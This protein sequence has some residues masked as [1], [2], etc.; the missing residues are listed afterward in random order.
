MLVKENIRQQQSYQFTIV[1]LS[2]GCQSDLIMLSEE[3]RKTLRKKI[4][5]LNEVMRG[6]WLDA[7]DH[8]NETFCL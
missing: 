8:I 1:D 4:D 6:K 5:A 2:S 7:A 3:S